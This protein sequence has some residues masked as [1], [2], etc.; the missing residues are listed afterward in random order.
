MTLSEALIAG[1]S[2]IEITLN[3]EGLKRYIGNRFKASTIY[4]FNRCSNYSNNLPAQPL[5]QTSDG[6]SITGF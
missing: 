2:D 6:I 5:P 3:V 4:R 1:R